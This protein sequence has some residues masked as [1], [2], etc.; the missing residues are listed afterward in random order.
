MVILCVL[1]SCSRE[2]A[3]GLEESEANRG[4]VSLSRV[5]IDAEK[6]ADLAI[7]GRFRLVV[8]REEATAAITVLASDEIPR[9]RPLPLRDP[10]MIASPEADRTA[11]IAATGAQIERTLASIENV[12]DARVH[13]DVP[14]LDPLL[15]AM[16]ANSDKTP[17]ASASVLIRYRGA[18]PPIPLEDV[19][20][21][22]AFAVVGLS[23]SEVAVVF[24]SVPVA[25]VGGDR[26]FVH[27]GPVVVTR[28]SIAT[29]RGFGIAMLAAIAVLAST[30][31]L[32]V[33]KMR[34]LQR[35]T[36]HEADSS[37]R[38]PQ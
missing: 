6:T 7:D 8:P 27:L 15:A 21:L 9:A 4:V 12:L 37:V 17:H 14:V 10:G 25:T 33:A 26:E 32:L 16:G 38:S 13:L 19:R 34:Q 24:A 28:G 30:I 3:S 1:P 22:V 18:N 20:K 5:G 2:V 23:A 29:L 31:L 36:E 35:A 11:R